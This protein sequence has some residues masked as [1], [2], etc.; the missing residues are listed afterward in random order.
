MT[1][2]KPTKTLRV[3]CQNINGLRLDAKGGD[4]NQIIETIKELEIDVVGFSEINLDVSK[5]KVQKILSQAFHSGFEAH[6]IASSTSTVPF[7]SNYK[8]GGTLT[9]VFNHTT[10]RFNS[11]HSDPM[12]RWSTMSLTGK[13]GRIVHFVTVYQVVDKQVLGPYTAYQQQNT[14]LRLADR[15]I[16]PRYHK[17]FPIIAIR[18]LCHSGH[19]RP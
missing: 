6:Q 8:P 3:F 17:V 16:S 4:I 9:S 10:C 15:Q 19:G 2:P 5:Y 12:G 7:A 13:R 11:K 14:I 18:Q 1:D